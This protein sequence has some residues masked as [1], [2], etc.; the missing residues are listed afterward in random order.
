MKEGTE[1]QI[2]TLKKLR[3]RLGIN[4]TE[5]SRKLG[6]P[7]RTVEQWEA[8]DRK[9]PDYLLRFLAYYVLGRELLFKDRDEEYID[10]IEESDIKIQ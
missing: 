7:L 6:I 8:G 3:N 10:I 2:D 9:M 1:K 4:R 5:F